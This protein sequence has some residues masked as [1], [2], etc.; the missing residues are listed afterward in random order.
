MHALLSPLLSLVLSSYSFFACDCLSLESLSLSFS[1]SLSL[2]MFATVTV[3]IDYRLC[4]RVKSAMCL[5]YSIRF[6]RKEEHNWPP[7]SLSLF[8]FSFSP[9][10]SLIHSF[11][12]DMSLHSL[13]HPKA[14]VGE[15]RINLNGTT[16]GAKRIADRK[17]NTYSHSQAYFSS[18]CL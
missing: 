6:Y 7:L 2:S 10:H 5:L 11:M 1:F 13:L 14:K 4:P 12:L 17:Y 9:I 3:A 16:A 18:Y 15:R 8:F